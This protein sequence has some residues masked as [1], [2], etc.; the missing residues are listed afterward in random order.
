MSDPATD[1]RISPAVGLVLLESLRSADLPDEESLEHLDL[2]EEPRRLGLSAAVVEQIQRYGQLRGR[3]DALP[4]RE[5]AS[6]FELISRRPDAGAV[7]GE[8]GRRLARRELG[9]PVLRSRLSSLTLPRSARYRL[10]LRRVKRLARQVSP[11]GEVRV[12]RKPP[13]L[14]VR[15]SLP[16]RAASGSAGCALLRGAMEA[17]LDAYRAGDVEVEHRRCEARDDARCIWEVKT[18][19]SADAPGEA[20]EPREPPA[21]GN[22]GEARESGS[23][24]RDPEA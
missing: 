20:A 23:G 9:E 3:R 4:T 19:H 15:G 13:R 14:S 21:G 6:L 12:E 17:V 1:A 16:A 8:A 22:G 18:S 11:D 2:P 5:V 10:A 24:G 7:F